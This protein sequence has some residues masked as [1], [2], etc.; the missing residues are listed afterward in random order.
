VTASSPWEKKRMGK[1]RKLFLV[2][3]AAVV[4]LPLLVIAAFYIMINGGIVNTIRNL[5]PEPDVGSATLQSDRTKLEAEIDSAF[6]TLVA[7]TRLVYYATSTHDRCY[8]GQNNFHMTEGF[9][10]RCTLQQ[11][12]FYGFDGDF[13][14]SMV[15]FEKGALAAGWNLGR[16]HSNN[17]GEQDMQYMMTHY[18]DVRPNVTV[19]Q[20]ARPIGYNRDNLVLDL[21]WAERATQHF[22][23]LDTM[24]AM[25]FGALASYDQASFQSGDF[26]RRVTQQHR[27][28]LGIAIYG[29]YF[30]N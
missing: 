29:H 26:F 17:P 5:E 7:N 27:Y 22:D 28:L 20:I 12:R 30:E 21:N 4:S 13:R 8:G 2:L 6:Q 11:T 18:Y 3:L 19:D 15:D 25:D 10:H 23:S 9:A 14:Q 1:Y 16:S 24:Q